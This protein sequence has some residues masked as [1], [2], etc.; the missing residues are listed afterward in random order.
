MVTRTTNNKIDESKDKGQPKRKNKDSFSSSHIL[1]YQIRLLS[2]NQNQ[3]TIRAFS[4][5]LER[6]RMVNLATG[7]GMR[8]A[9]SQE[10]G[11]SEEER[12]H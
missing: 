8:V 6:Q 10:T 4:S 12:V 3:G 11:E 7:G 9:Q 2:P 5:I 1:H